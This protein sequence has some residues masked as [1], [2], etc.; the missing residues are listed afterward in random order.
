MVDPVVGGSAIRGAAAAAPFTI[1]VVASEWARRDAHTSDFARLD[2]EMDEAI[3]V[4]GR[5]GGLLSGGW[6]RIKAAAS[7]VPEIY[8]APAIRAWLVEPATRAAVK[9]AGQA[10]MLRESEDRVLAHLAASAPIEAAFRSAL[11]VAFDY[12]VA[13][14]VRSVDR[15]LSAG[16]RLTQL[17]FDSLD[18]QMY[19][20][21]QAQAAHPTTTLQ[22]ELLDRR[23]EHEVDRLRRRRFFTGVDVGGEAQVIADRLT[24]GALR[25][26]SDSVRARGLASCARWLSRADGSVRAAEF[27]A[28]ARELADVEEVRIAE[29]F[30]VDQADESAALA[31]LAPID[32]ALRREAA[33]AIVAGARGLPAALAWADAAAIDVQDLTA[34]GRRLLLMCALQADDW[35][36]AYQIAVAISP[37]DGDQSPAGLPAAAMARLAAAVASDQRALVR[38]GPPF[39]AATFSLADGEA[40]LADRRAAA[41]LFERGAD[42]AMQLGLRDAADQMT[43]QALWLRLRDPEAAVAA[44]L[45]LAAQLDDPRTALSVAPLAIAF[46]IPF[47]RARL[48]AELDRQDALQPA[49][50]P[51]SAIARFALL[52]DAKDPELGLEALRKHRVRLA[53]HLTHDALASLEFQ[54][55]LQL[56]RQEDA[57]ALL[58]DN[59]GQ[60]DAGIY[61]RMRARLASGATGPTLADLESWY[62]TQPTTATLRSL[63]DRLARAEYT[64]RFFQLARE[65]VATTRTVS[66]AEL[67]LQRLVSADRHEEAA[68][69]LGDVAE[70]IPS[71]LELQSFKAWSDFRR[72]DFRSAWSQVQILRAAR[73]D[74]NDR[75]LFSNILIASGRWPELV[76]YVE[77]EWEHR[78]ARGCE[79]LLEL[80]NLSAALGSQRA[81]G[82]VELAAARSPDDPHVLLGA[83]TIATRLGLDGSATSWHWFNKA[84]ELSDETG[85]VTPANLEELLSHSGDWRRRTDEV[86]QKVREGELPLFI[87]A[88]FLRRSWLELQLVPLLANPNEPDPRR[89]ALV[90]LF[91]GERGDVVDLQGDIALDGS[92]VITLGTLGL[93]E[94]VRDRPG[95]LTL[96]HGTLTWLFTE[97]E[98]LR[99]HQPSR[100][101]EARDLIQAVAGHRLHIFATMTPATPQLTDEVGQ[102]LAEMLLTAQ[103]AEEGAPQTLVV[104]P[105]PVT[106]VG[107]FRGEPADLGDAERVLVSCGAVIDKLVERGRLTEEEEEEARAYLAQREARWP[108]E[109]VID[110]NAILFLD[111]L[112]ISYLRFVGVLERL[113]EAGLK[114]Y[115]SAREF[116]EANALLALEARAGL[117]ETTLEAIRKPLAEG[118]ATGAIRVG[119]VVDSDDDLSAHPNVAAVHLASSV[120]II[121][122]DERFI[123]KNR[124]VRDDIGG[125][126]AVWTSLD[127]IERLRRDGAIDDAR[128]HRARTQLRRGGAIFVPPTS[129]EL[130]AMVARSRTKE[131][132]LQESGEMRAFRENLEMAQMYRW[133]HLPSEAQW[134]VRL[135]GAVVEAVLEQWCDE[136]AD[137]DA[138]ARSDWLICCGDVSNWTP[139]LPH[140]DFTGMGQRGLPLML[141]RVLLGIPQLASE[142]AQARLTSWLRDEYLDPL[143]QADPVNHAWLISHLRQLILRA[144]T[145]NAGRLND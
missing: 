132:A 50:D 73:E 7:G 60:L 61:H 36:R 119:Q 54:F 3:D 38:S 105:A 49:G 121:V 16:D 90:P 108:H 24:S 48:Q 122:S 58:E 11:P 45:D 26:A 141:V 66:D 34:D 136:V 76:G 40:A 55:L 12:A 117:I 113:H 78:E 144:A 118:I 123:N 31:K 145:A 52:S 46:D 137:A 124:T 21:R 77:S 103:A 101:R 143:R 83:Y 114:V 80:A 91:S 35:S 97:R 39:D 115:V 98:K 88:Q 100:I 142:S 18:T 135:Q 112:S 89:R 68:L 25:A 19:E 131:G 109:P 10:L 111:D 82:F 126:A 79:Q 86:W 23:A 84:I 37:E 104:H 33:L 5:E 8:A 42:A 125:E 138:R 110:D 75:A 107:S 2:R 6:N 70:L 106:K 17:R 139:T 27:L 92:A 51:V 20:L 129:E 128:Y 116:E 87:A 13:F 14:V 127:L 43:A 29:A 67:T 28:R 56:D 32:S 102:T 120:A 1:K 41:D 94:A 99:F 53:K 74:R 140:G 64:P 72:G 93:L 95:G 134:L 44:R 15:N 30:L 65:L 96:P 69:L 47:D 63:V 71:S 62:A 57:R 85:P 59:A 133:L 22:R 4:L 130:R 9:A 81:M